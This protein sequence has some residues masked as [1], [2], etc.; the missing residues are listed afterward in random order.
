[1]G[2][3]KKVTTWSQDPQRLDYLSVNPTRDE[4]THYKVNPQIESDESIEK[5]QTMKDFV[6]ITCLDYSETVPGMVGIGEREGFVKIFD[7]FQNEQELC[8]RAKQQ[9]CVNSIGINNVGMVAMGLDRIRHDSSLKVWDVNYQKQGEEIVNTT[10]EYC[11]NESIVSLKFL[12]DINLIVASTK[13]LKEIDLR[14]KNPVYQH[15]TRLSYDIK[16]NPFNEWQFSTYGD[17]GTLAIWDRR[18]LVGHLVSADL[19]VATPLLTFE[20]LVG[21][22]AASRKYMNSCF[23]WST[24]HKGEFATLHRGD[25]IKRWRLGSCTDVDDYGNMNE[26]LFVSRVFDITTTFDRVATFDYIPKSKH[27]TSLICMRHSG[28]VYRMPVIESYSKA[29]FNYNNSLLLTNSEVPIIDE[30]EVNQKQEKSNPQ[31]VTTG[32][33]NLSFEDLAAVDDYTPNDMRMDSSLTSDEDYADEHHNHLHHSD[34]GE[35]DPLYD[36]DEDPHNLLEEDAD[37]NLYWKPERLLQKDISVIMRMR[38]K[39]GYG[40]DPITTV[41]TIDKSKALQDNT[42]IRNTWR[43]IAIAKASVDD[44]TMVSGDLD[45][46]YEGILG[47]W[48][49]LNGFSNQNRYREDTILSDK[50]LNKEMEKIIRLRK[51][52]KGGSSHKNLMSKFS[53]SPKIIQRRLCLI[54]SGWDLSPTDYEEKYNLIIKN[55]HY[56]KAAAWAVFFGDIPKAV[57]ILGS[58]KKEKLR[59]IATAI[60]GY[61]AYKDQPGNNAW[62]QQCRKMSSEL[63]DP[64]LRVIFAFIADN[65]WWDIL[66]EPAISLRE[67]LGVA[68]RFLND[69]D[70]TRFLERTSSTVIANGELE[71]MILTGITPSGINLLQSYVHKT[72][73]VQT[74]A[75]ISSFG[76]PRYFQDQRVEEWVATYR[77]MLN[78]WKLF[79]MRAKFDILRTKLSIN[80]TGEK[81]IKVKS[82]QLY[83]QC[84]NCKKNINSP[85]AASG[86]NQNLNATNQKR[87][88]SGGIEEKV[89]HRYACPHCGTPYPRCAICLM[90]LGTSNLPFIINGVQT[91]EELRLIEDNMAVTGISPQLKEECEST[92]ARRILR[93]NEWFSFCLTCNHG[94]HAGHADEWFAKHSICPTPGCRCQCNRK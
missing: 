7:I 25:T 51:R 19:S 45:L 17:D 13:F 16:L 65:D 44:G 20:K 15:P 52:N 10:F 55:G 32:L 29:V 63:E 39:V 38:A 78:S 35:N 31:N 91:D 70:L 58:A 26:N 62:R 21:A 69:V 24:I 41:E 56:E 90:P 76:C 59:L 84:I 67:R 73:D 61:M 2:L 57:E 36:A 92:I 85:I 37:F 68:L 72:S 46:G 3:I 6:N 75:L 60:A 80:S 64:Y 82:R 40:L 12:N 11:V 14:V 54:I 77:T 79:S 94:M 30:F 1:M 23:R 34:D 42:Y 49:G 87:L 53:D 71:G 83:V 27:T 4:V 5:T 8:V 9:R 43:W 33:K 66:Y 50:Q 88:N 86:S 47:I 28:T 93:L 48:N 81:T 89:Q 22:G 74:A 18:K